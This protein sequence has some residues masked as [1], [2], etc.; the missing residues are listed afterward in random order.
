[1]W[2]AYHR[3]EPAETAL[4]PEMAPAMVTMWRRTRSAPATEGKRRRES[5]RKMQLEAA[6]SKM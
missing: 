4:Q 1:M 5:V 2:A 3:F 6:P